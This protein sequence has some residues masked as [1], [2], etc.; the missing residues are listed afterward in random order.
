[1]FATALTSGLLLAGRMR[2]ISQTPGMAPC[3]WSGM[4]RVLAEKGASGLA[5]TSVSSIQTG[6]RQRGLVEPSSAAADAA[7]SVSNCPIT[8]S[9]G[10]PFW[11][12]ADAGSSV[13]LTSHRA[14]ELRFRARRG[15]GNGYSS[16]SPTLPLPAPWRISGPRTASTAWDPYMPDSH[17]LN[18]PQG[19][20]PVPPAGSGTMYWTLSATRPVPCPRPPP[21]S[22]C[23]G[24]W[25]VAR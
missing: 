14:L 22:W 21:R 7:T 6:T 12:M 17:F 2:S 25:S 24:G 5:G 16:G 11:T 18:P 3:C 9:S 23:S 4:I 15:G 20:V 10:T 8:P 1:M 19:P 13:K